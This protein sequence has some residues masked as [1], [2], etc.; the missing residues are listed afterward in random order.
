MPGSLCLKNWISIGFPVQP[1]DPVRVWKQWFG[2]WLFIS[3]K[4]FWVLKKLLEDYFFVSFSIIEI[5]LLLPKLLEML[6]C[7]LTKHN[8]REQII[9]QSFM[10]SSMDK[11]RCYMSINFWELVHLHVKLTISA[12]KA[13]T[14]LARWVFFFGWESS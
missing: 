7:L 4:T 13:R 2:E 11:P 1:P 14:T 12:Y 6:S 3:K 5:I 8:I 9:E 10:K